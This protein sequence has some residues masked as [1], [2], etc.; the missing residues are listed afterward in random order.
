M[1]PGEATARLKSGFSD[2]W[3]STKERWPGLDH[4]VRAYRHYK[5]NHG[6]HMA[7]AVTYFSFLALF[8][9]IL[10][11]VS[12][13]GFILQSHPGLR[14]EIFD[15]IAK[16]LPTEFGDTISAAVDSVVNSRAKVGLIGLLGVAFAGLGWIGNLRSAI[17]TIWGLIPPKRSFIAA[18]AADA[19]VLLGLGIGALV[20]VA[21]TV[22]GTAASGV[23][24]GRLGWRDVTGAELFAPV[25]G[26]LLAMIGSLVVFGWLLVRLPQVVVSRRTAVRTTVL[27]AIGFEVLELLGTYYIDA[28][29]KSPALGIFASVVGVLVWIDL[30]SR[31]LLYCVAWAATA[32]ASVSHPTAAEVTGHRVSAEKTSAKPPV[33]EV[34]PQPPPSPVTVAAGLLSAGV[35]VGGAAVATLQRA[36]SRARRRPRSG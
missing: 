28:A 23:V 33:T 19:F 2:R 17:D 11:G 31:Y 20:S 21:L 4:A 8:P 29:T 1:S 5:D 10:L 6:D 14:T 34:H 35:I 18:R 25:L 30:V 7:A 32:D 16:N 36:R 15:S 27:A 9:L 22:G 24:L 12:V 13:A 26:V 3:R